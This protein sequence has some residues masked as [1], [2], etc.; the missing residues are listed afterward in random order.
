MWPLERAKTDSDWARRSRSRW[1]SRTPHGSTVYAACSIMRGAAPSFADQLGEVLDD[2]VGAVLAQ[3]LGVVDAVDADDVAEVTGMAGFDPRD[4]V[5]EDGG[6]G[7]LD[8]HGFGPG[9]VAVG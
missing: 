8:A 2:D 1:V 3:R 6:G 4:G 7:R 5:L 9:Q